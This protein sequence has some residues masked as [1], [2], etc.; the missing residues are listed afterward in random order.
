[1]DRDTLETAIEVWWVDPG[2]GAYPDSLDQVGIYL[3]ADFP[4]DE[5]TYARAGTGYTLT[6]A[7]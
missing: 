6:G 2:A 7:C 1:M 4:L 3:D 5:W